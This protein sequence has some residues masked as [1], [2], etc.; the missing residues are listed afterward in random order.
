MDEPI[1]FENKQAWAYWLT[2]NHDRSKA[3]WLRLDKKGST[4]KAVTYAEA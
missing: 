4:Q 2:H 3:I 1:L